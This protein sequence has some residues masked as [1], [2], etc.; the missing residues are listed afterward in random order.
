MPRPEKPI[1]PAW[2]LAFFA[3]GLRE[4]RNKRGITYREMARLTHYGITTLSMAANGQSLPTLEVTLA[5]VSVCN[6][7]RDDWDRR[8]HQA[9]DL[10]QHGN[11]Q[12]HG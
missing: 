10:L 3:G 11:G 7:C 4:L 8:W 5:Y 12:G 6:G 2:P 1:N 9:R